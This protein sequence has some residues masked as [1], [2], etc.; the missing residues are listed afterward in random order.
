[1]CTYPLG[2]VYLP[3]RYRSYWYDLK[4]FFQLDVI[5]NQCCY[6][7]HDQLRWDRNRPWELLQHP[8]LLCSPVYLEGDFDLGGLQ[9]F[10]K[11][12]EDDQ[13]DDGYCRDDDGGP[14]DEPHIL[15]HCYPR[16]VCVYVCVCVHMCV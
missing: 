2:I 4:L 5:R 3:I 9:E 1:M 15:E 13:E 6:D 7:H 10:V 14:V 16:L 11:N 8:L 12:S